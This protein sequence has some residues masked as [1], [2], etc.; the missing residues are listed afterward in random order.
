MAPPADPTA[1]RRRGA[2]RRAIEPG[3]SRHPP[4]APRAA[5]GPGVPTG[6]RLSGVRFHVHTA[7]PPARAARWRPTDPEY[8]FNTLHTLGGLRGT[9]LLLDR[10]ASSWNRGTAFFIIGRRAG[11][12]G[13]PASSPGLVAAH[14]GA[15]SPSDAISAISDSTSFSPPRTPSTPRDTLPG[16]AIETRAALTH[17][18]CAWTRCG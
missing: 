16:A 10:L 17:L 9:K 5:S 14:D 7:S 1:R 8:T 2:P 13:L 15:T 6:M 12:Y 18:S 11:Y 3:R 4:R